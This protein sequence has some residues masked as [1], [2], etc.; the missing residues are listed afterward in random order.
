MWLGSVEV[1]E[2]WMGRWFLDVVGGEQ[3][4][5][6]TTEADVVIPTFRRT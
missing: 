1:G 2:D 3:G 6:N 5:S 4:R